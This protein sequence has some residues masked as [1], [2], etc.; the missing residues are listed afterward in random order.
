[1]PAVAENAFA[2]KSVRSEIICSTL[3]DSVFDLGTEHFVEISIQRWMGE[4]GEVC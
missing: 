2:E 3:F 4:R 1:M